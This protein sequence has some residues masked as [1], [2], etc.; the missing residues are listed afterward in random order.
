MYKRMIKKIIL[1]FALC[2]LS[3]SLYAQQDVNE[4]GRKF[5]EFSKIKPG[6]NEVVKID[7]SGLSLY[8]LIMAISEEHQLN[9]SVDNDLNIPVVNNFYDVTVKDAFLFLVQK[10]DL[11]ASFMSNIIIFKKRKEVK[12]VVKKAPKI[13]DVSYNPQNDFLS[14]KLENDSLPAVAQAII[15]KSGKNLVLA[16][17]IKTL[18][19]SSYI[20]NR[21]FDQVIE[22]MA[23]SNDLVATKDDNGF[24][25]LEKNTLPKDPNLSVNSR[26][27]TKSKSKPAS[28]SEGFYDVEINEKG[29][30]SVKANVA[31]A[32]D[33]LIEAAEKLNVNYFIYNKPEN[34]KTSLLA[35]NITFDNLL[36]HVFKGKKYTYRNQDGLYLIGEQSTEGLR[37]T[38]I[39]SLENRSIESVLQSLPKIFNDK[40]EIKEFVELN[41]LIVSGSKSTIEELKLY[42]KQIDKVVPLVQIEVIIVQYNKSYD[43]QTGLKAGLDRLNQNSTSGALFPT[44]DVNLNSSSVNNLIDAFNGLGFIKLGKVTDAFYLNL[45]VLENNSIIKIE[46]TP[47]IAT[48]SGHEAT[49]SIGETSYYFEQ[50]NR[51]LNNNIGNGGDI[52]Q[53]GTWKNTE[54]NLS[55]KIKPF[56]STDENVTLNINVEKSSF[57]GRAGENAPPGKATQKFESLVRVRNNEMVLLGGLDEL[58]KENSGTGV[59]LISR[60]PIIKWFFSSKKKA[61]GNSKLHIFIKPTIVY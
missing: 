8:D 34:E 53:S 15:D 48:L 35:N 9:V 36:E 19:I 22:M 24:Y 25:F 50:N 61:K 10:Y 47:K 11:E 51:I 23:K 26:G 40:V 37:S 56:V 43:I 57:L 17:D 33:L 32:T 28:G 41:S 44:T 7:V 30:L 1:I 52:L 21:P 4:L 55:V 39:I 49:L 3:G 38:E 27:A 18:K 60:I 14:V 6:I 16:P 29:F 58:K 13:I 42:I 12:I 20:L 2:L 31:D 45:K 46:S 54:A 59:P 5:D